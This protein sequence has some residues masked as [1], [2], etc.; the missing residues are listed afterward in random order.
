MGDL[1]NADLIEIGKLGSVDADRFSDDPSLKYIGR[2]F[3][4]TLLATALSADYNKDTKELKISTS[5]YEDGYEL[6]RDQTSRKYI[7]QNGFGAKT[8]VTEIRG[9]AYGI[10][11]PGE[12]FQKKPFVY[13]TS[14]E[15]QDA[16]EFSKTLSLRLTGTIIPADGIWAKK[17]SIFFEHD[18]ISD[19]TVSD[20][21]DDFVRRY[22]VAA[23]FT[24]AEWIDVRTGAVVNSESF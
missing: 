7:G 9:Y 17:G 22:Y 15:P 3:V 18:I 10:E 2:Q 19:A 21:Y 8:V 4:V 5:S 13:A 16:K 6:R 23:K 20:P 12:K 24:K 11:Y 14:M 1:N